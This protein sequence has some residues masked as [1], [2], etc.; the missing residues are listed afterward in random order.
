[1]SDNTLGTTKDA[2][3][4][5]CCGCKQGFRVW[6]DDRN[7]P[8][9][10][11]VPF[12]MRCPNCG[13]WMMLRTEKAFHLILEEPCEIRETMFRLE[14]NDKYNTSVFVPASELTN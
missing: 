3:Q 2:Y 10:N 8:H 12:S 5:E 4:Y 9:G 6:D 13:S 11:S 7:A 14:F 1:M